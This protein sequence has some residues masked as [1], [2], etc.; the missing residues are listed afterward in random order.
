MSILFASM[1]ADKSGIPH[2]LTDSARQLETQN[3]IVS[4]LAVWTC[5]HKKAKT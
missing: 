4:V 5:A 2:I 3:R 1:L